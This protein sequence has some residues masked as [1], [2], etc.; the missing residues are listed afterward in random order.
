MD[1][2]RPAASGQMAHDKAESSTL[3]TL[4]MLTQIAMHLMLYRSQE[5]RTR[6]FDSS[7]VTRMYLMRASANLLN[8]AIT[9]ADSALEPS[10][11]PPSLCVRPCRCTVFYTYSIY[12]G[13]D[14]RIFVQ[15][16]VAYHP[17][18]SCGIVS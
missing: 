6:R 17:L 14:H 5:A 2:G 8:P 10:L 16:P 9:C 1:L 3:D 13:S 11:F 7:R 12:R 4:K 18:E 15:T